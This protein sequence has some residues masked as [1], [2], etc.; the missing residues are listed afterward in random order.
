MTSKRI[1]IADD[2]ATSRVALLR[3][4]QKWGYQVTTCADGE[5]ALAE[6]ERPNAPELAILDWMM[7]GLDGVDVCRRLRAKP[8]ATYTY[9]LM[10]TSKSQH[11]DLLDGLEAGADDYLT[12][13]FEYKELQVRLRSGLRILQLQSDLIA[14]REEVREQA[15]HDD[16]TGLWN[17]RSVMES[18]GREL[19][20]ANR[21]RTCTGVMMLDLD[22]FKK[23]NDRYGH[24]AGDQFLRSVAAQLKAGV[25][26]YDTA[27]RFGG[28]EFL[29][30]LPNCDERVLAKR[31]E[32]FRAAIENSPLLLEGQKTVLTASI[33]ATVYH[34]GI[35]CEPNDILRTAD[36][37][38]YE[39]KRAGRNRSVLRTFQPEL[40][41]VGVSPKLDVSGAA[42]PESL[43]DCATPYFC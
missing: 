18:L 17:R 7:P 33:G 34:G 22:Y 29:V 20:R 13:P 27:G 2:C 9:L 21:Q 25:R 26:T 11:E 40:C 28:E 32:D 3:T 31:A 1:L 39:A 8:Q 23:V 38:L 16:L 42:D 43:F 30:V 41:S 4:L 6:L 36:E 5:T 37:A 24:L 35:P 15:T 10:L 14:A 19:S 12:K